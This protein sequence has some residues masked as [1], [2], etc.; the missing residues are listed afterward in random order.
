MACIN[1]DSAAAY[2]MVAVQIS[3][4]LL[5]V[6]RPVAELRS[7]SRQRT[8]AD[9]VNADRDHNDGRPIWR[10]WPLTED[11]D[12]QQHSQRQGKVRQKQR[13]SQADDAEIHW[14]VEH[15]GADSGDGSG[16]NPSSRALRIATV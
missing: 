14:N 15:Q 1:L 6:G 4:I 13:C 3:R 16:I 2:S 10:R 7:T 5:Q 9:D 11:R 12:C 8:S